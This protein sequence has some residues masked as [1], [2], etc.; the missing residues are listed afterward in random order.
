LPFIPNKVVSV[1]DFTN[2]IKDDKLFL[3]SDHLNLKG[4]ELFTS[5]MIE[6]FEE[7]RVSN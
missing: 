2:A 6:K 4:A 1:Y 5:L 7:N 3:N